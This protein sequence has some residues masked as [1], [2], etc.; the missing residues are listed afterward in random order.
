MNRNQYFL[1]AGASR[2][3]WYNQDI[4]KGPCI[5][6]HLLTI[7]LYFTINNSFLLQGKQIKHSFIVNNF[8]LN[9]SY[10]QLLIQFYSLYLVNYK[11]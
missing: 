10:A 11:P 1:R 2:N 7:N 6:S 3:I 9:F 8:F 4:Q 5:D